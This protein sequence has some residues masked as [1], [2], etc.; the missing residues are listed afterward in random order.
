MSRILLVEDAPE[1]VEI[2]VR[3]LGRK[4]HDVLVA[5]TKADAIARAT[6]EQPDLILMDIGIPNAAGEGANRDGGIEAAQAI[7]ASESTSSI[8]IIALTAFAMT[9]EKARYLNA[10][11]DDVQTKPYEFSTLL[12]AIDS[13]LAAVKSS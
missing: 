9:D 6:A 5:A 10:G 11:C 7:K 8:P 2:L 12:G 1:N 13:H 3:L 4:G